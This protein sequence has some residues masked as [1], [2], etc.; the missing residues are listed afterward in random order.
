MYDKKQ[1]EVNMNN[2]KKLWNVI[3]KKIGKNSK[4]NSNIKYI[5]D[6][7]KKITDP[8]NIVEHLNKFFCNIGKKLIDKIKPPKNEKIKLPPMNCKTIFLEP[9]NHQEIEYIIRTMENKN[10]GIDNINTITLK[11]LIEHLVDP[12]VHIFNLCIEQA[13]WPDALK[14]AE[15]IPIHKSKEKYSATNYR[16]ISLISNLAKILE[17][18]IHK[19]ITNFINKCDILA[20]NQYGFR[21]DKGTKDA[22]SLI[23]NEIYN[24]LDKSTPIAI[25][26]LDLAKA[27]DTVNHQ[28]LLEKLYNYG[29][30]GSAHNLLKRYLSNRQQKVKL[31]KVSS[32]LETVDMG[33]PQGTI[34]GPLL[35]LLYINDLLQIIPEDS[36]VAYADDTAIVTTAKTRKEV[37]TKMNE[38]LHIVSTWISLNKLS[39]NTDKTVYIE[40]GNQVNST[41][42]NLNINIQGTK[43]KRVESNKYLGI[44]FD[45][46][47]R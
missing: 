18:I 4:K 27:F 43:I 29:I 19:R 33:V 38:T 8:D 28:L 14:T 26:F 17:K 5:I 3:N 39:L 36:I 15:V 47:M 20:K 24:K 21:K 41:P 31:N 9:T 25:T 46:N 12:L 11:T 7:N 1:I 16:P 10:G 44:I 2:P 30:R 34:L 13:I 32:Q 42:K 40:F 37:E 6:N 22:L 35:F 45:S 23:A